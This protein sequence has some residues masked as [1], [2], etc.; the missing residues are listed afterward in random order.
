M[1]APSSRHTSAGSTLSIAGGAEM[2]SAPLAVASQPAGIGIRDRH[3]VQARVELGLRHADRDRGAHL[4]LVRPGCRAARS[5]PCRPPRSPCRRRSS[6][7]RCRRCAGSRCPRSRARDP[8]ARRRPA[9]G[10]R[11]R[12]WAAARRAACGPR[13]SCT[14]RSRGSRAS[15]RESRCAIASAGSSTLAPLHTSASMPS[16]ATSV[17]SDSSSAKRPSTP[18]TASSACASSLRR[19]VV[20]VELDRARA[21]RE[22]HDA[23]A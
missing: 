18:S 14:P 2:R 10:S 20:P 22:A 5:R 15:A 9:A 4:D 7:A 1:R 17:Q 13:C 16:C 12:C 19:K 6:P 11:G 3:L 21:L 23:R 8:P